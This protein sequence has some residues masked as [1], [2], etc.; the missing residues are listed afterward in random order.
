MPCTNYFQIVGDV[1]AG[2]IDSIA[3]SRHISYESA[4]EEVLKYLISNSAQWNSGRQPEIHYKDPL[5]R[6]AYLYGIVPVNEL[7]SKFRSY[8]KLS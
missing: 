4:H 2:S 7:I 3:Q 5:C 1:I 8:S 6:L